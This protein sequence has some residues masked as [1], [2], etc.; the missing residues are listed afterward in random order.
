MCSLAAFDRVTEVYTITVKGPQI[1]ESQEEVIQNKRNEWLR[2]V[3][4]QN[5]PDE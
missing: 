1:N 5:H 3:G 4:C 2:L